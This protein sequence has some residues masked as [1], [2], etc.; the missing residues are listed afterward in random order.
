MYLWDYLSAKAGSPN[1]E[2]PSATQYQYSYAIGPTPQESGISRIIENVIKTPFSAQAVQ[3]AECAWY[4]VFCKVGK[5]VS[6]AAS[7][8]MDFVSSTM[9]KVIILV[10]IAAI[11]GLFVMSYAQAKGAQFAK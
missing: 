8:G 2:F 1:A 6:S 7:G 11:V 5:T 4:N 3:P 9:N 10:V